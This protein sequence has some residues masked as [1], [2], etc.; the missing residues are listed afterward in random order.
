[1][2]I[3]G[4][5]AGARLAAGEKG[6]ES[7]SEWR[8]YADPATDLEVFR[9]TDPEHSSGMP[10]GYNR[11]FARGSG[12]M[13]FWSDRGGSR[14]AFRM[15]LRSGETR[16]VTGA[17][18]LDGSS[19]VLT[20]DNRSFCY[21]AGRSLWL[22]SL[23]TLK[24]RELYALPEGWDRCPGMSVEPDGT[25]A[26]FTERR[27]GG[28]RLRMVSLAHGAA[29]TVMEA[30]FEMAHP[31]P[32]PG[33]QARSQILYR[34][35]DEALWMVNA[36]GKQNRQVPAAPGRIGTANWSTDGKTVLYLSLPED[37]SQLN[38]I[39]EYEPDGKTDK[40]VAKTSQFADFGFNRDGS[41]FV[42]ASRNAA[43]P[44]ILLLL[45]ATRRELTI[46][47]HK[48]SHPES[49]GPRF[50]PDSQRIYFESDRH[51][52]P[53]IYCM[54]VERLVEKTGGDTV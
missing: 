30:L 54:H 5:A 46:C 39:R 3:S 48:A 41:V 28:S 2:L 13:L 21:F 24:E 53:A 35:G 6:A 52:K 7:A 33:G 26:L 20:P 45:R 11:T 42:G 51:G 19:L 32:R 16:Q 44:T 15:E 14:Q 37:R 9:L 4:L 1:V 50:A 18:D 17:E 22:A 38:A 47:E 34:R 12:W 29:R 40:L 23:A 10:A 27:G 31:I 49:V 43:S 25:H 8:R 36:D